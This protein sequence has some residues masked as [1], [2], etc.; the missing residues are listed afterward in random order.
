MNIPRIF[1]NYR[2]NDTGDIASALYR[3]LANRL[4]KQNIFIDHDR[5]EAGEHWPERLRSE[6]E[7]CNIMLCLIGCQWLSA[8]DDERNKRRI[9][10]K[11]DWVIQEI[12]YA[13]KLG[14]VILPIIVGDAN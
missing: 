2:V 3:E 5:I 10:V 7:Q 14:K 1:L 6:V 9:D 11:E 8:W 13:L 12:S 4:G